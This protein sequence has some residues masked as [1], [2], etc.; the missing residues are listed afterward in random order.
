MSLILFLLMYIYYV[1]IKNQFNFSSSII[2]ALSLISSDMSSWK[3]Y[4]IFIA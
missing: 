3:T 1:N 4:T 2:I